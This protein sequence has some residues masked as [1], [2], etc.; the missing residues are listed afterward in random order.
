MAV[1]GLSGLVNWAGAGHAGLDRGAYHF[2]TLCTPGAV[3]AE[4]FLRVVTAKNRTL[5]PAIDLELEGNCAA[6]PSWRAVGR[7][8]A[9]FVRRVE[10]ALGQQTVLYVSG[11]FESL[12]PIHSA[13]V[14]PRWVRRFLLRPHEDWVIW[15][16][17][18][19]ASI[20]GI[21]GG[22]DLDVMCTR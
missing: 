7:E 3:Q 13:L 1:D 9:T 20:D 18:G 2:F 8:F 4:N 11:D 15:Q 6:R 22:V 19:F 10:N 17:Q 16:V 5:P 21:R 14:R 12:Y